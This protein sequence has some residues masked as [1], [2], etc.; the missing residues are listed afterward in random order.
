MTYAYQALAILYIYVPLAALASV[1]ALRWFKWQDDMGRMKMTKGA[2]D[3][4]R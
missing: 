1:M 4:H 3:V 2:Y